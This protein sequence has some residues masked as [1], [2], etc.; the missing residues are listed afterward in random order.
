MRVVLE[1]PY[2]GRP[3]ALAIRRLISCLADIWAD[4]MRRKPLPPI[5]RSSVRYEKEPNAG[6]WE[7]FD[8][9]W[10]AVA[11]GWADCDDAVAWR[12][13]ELRNAGE[14]AAHVQVIRKGKRFHVRVRRA[15]GRVED[16]SVILMKKNNH[17]R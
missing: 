11:R 3:L 17:D 7:A 10:A 8:H 14:H 9:P 16:P 4:G 5:Y 1:I 13:A 2:T 6:Q 15:S 12:V